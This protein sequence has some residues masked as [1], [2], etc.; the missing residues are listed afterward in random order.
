MNDYILSMFAEKHADQPQPSGSSPKKRAAAAE[1][2][3]E[4][5]DPS[6]P[7]PARIHFTEA[8]PDS[9]MS[10]RYPPLTNTMIPSISM[11]VGGTTH[12]ILKNL[13]YRVSQRELEHLVKQYGAFK[14][15]SLL[16]PHASFLNL[17]A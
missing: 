8:H 9:S 14:Y 10:L 4:D 7:P 15:C 2:D 6:E 11:P 16:I 13:P 3:S 1:S 12:A 5:E 17:H